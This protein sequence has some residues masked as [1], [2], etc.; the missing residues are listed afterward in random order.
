MKKKLML[1]SACFA[2]SAG[3]ASAQSRVTGTVTDTDGNPVIGATVK[4]EGT[5][6]VTVTDDDGKFSFQSV[7]ASAKHLMV[8]Y[9]GM[10][11]KRV[12]V[13]GNVR[14]TMAYKD[15]ELDEAMVVA[16]GTAKKSSFTGSV[17]EI[18]GDKI[19]TMQLSNIGK[20]LEGALAGVQITQPTGQP[21]EDANIYVR[22]IG[23]I[24]ASKNP[25]IVLDGVPTSL[26]LNAINSK[27]I[28][29]INVLKDAAAAAL[30]GS[31]GSNGVIIITTRKGKAGK[32]NINFEAKWGFNQRGVPAYRTVRN[33]G[34]YYELSWEA[35]R[36]QYM[37]QGQSMLQAGIT[38][39]KNLIT[40]LGGYNAYNVAN[41]R[42]INPVTGL[43]DR[44]ASLL[45]HDD[46][47]DEPFHNGFRQEYNV[48]IDGGNDKTKYYMSFNYLDDG[49][50]VKSSSFERMTGRVNLEHQATRWLQVGVNATFAHTDT[51]T[52]LQNTDPESAESQANGL[53]RFAQF[54]A[55]I[56]PI[57][58]YDASG[59]RL[60][61]DNGSAL[62]DYGVSDGHSRPYAQSANPYGSLNND[63]NS[64]KTDNLA[65]R[66]FAKFDLYDG[67]TFTAN[68]SYEGRWDR[69]IEFQTPVV[70]DA[71]NVNGRGFVRSSNYATVNANQLL[72][73]DKT[74][75]LHGVEALVGHE[76]YSEGSAD[77]YGY[78]EQFFL[79][80][81]PEFDNAAK[82]LSLGS[83]TA[84]YTLESYFGRVQYSYADKYYV[85]GSYR[86]DGS[87]RFHP[88]HRWGNFWSVGA[89]WR[90]KEESW[91][92]DVD[93]LHTLKLKASYGT[94]GNDALPY[95]TPYVDLYVVENVDDQPGLV[96]KFRGNP[97]ITWEKSKNFNVGV[98]V[99]LWN[100]LDVSAEFFVKNTDD[101]L[102]KRLLAF[103]EG[104]PSFYYTNEM[105][106]RNTGVEVEVGAL[107][108]KTR[109][110]TWRA[111]LNLTHYKNELTRLEQGKDPNGY[112]YN[113]YWRKK[114]GSIYDWYL[115]RYVG[116]DPENGDALYLKNVTDEEGN[117]IGTTTTNNSSMADRYEIGKSALPKLYGGLSTTLEGYGF[118]LTIQTAF[119]FGGWVDDS[120]YGSLMSASMGSNYS[121]DIYK[122]WTPNNRYTDVPRL[123]KDN[124]SLNG[125]NSD[126]FLT[127]ASYFSIRNITLGYTLPKG[128]L[129]QYGIQAVRFFAVGDNLFL[130][131][132]RKGFD[133]R[134]NIE[135]TVSQAVYSAV[136]TVSFGLNLQF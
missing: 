80:D 135:G 45:Y 124:T 55:P 88:D 70:G 66:A 29:S 16:Y 108:V 57:Y 105:A 127:K 8:S 113:S 86:R 47:L 106:M 59:N 54:I 116:V 98:E 53:F 63:I 11:A 31:R 83:N 28:E 120:S 71:A 1:V 85:S 48:G 46:W 118:D 25:L 3:I 26:S 117:I 84:K 97:D 51:N 114:G 101:M 93:W 125:G 77:L 10:D 121:P 37:G 64:Y 7:P 24:L 87:S 13:S 79:S 34:D 58:Q 74:F 68:F 133:P 132:A 41:D 19:A 61:D 96:R 75:G 134:Q 82:M 73:Y 5:K 78:K 128:W 107:L 49:S 76:S 109:N 15:T 50:Y 52:P 33:E 12:S 130:G 136:R 43:M 40:E 110:F 122:R 32:T 14:V 9:I 95:S 94:Q 60:Y 30:Y 92:K 6:L 103:T 104:S 62:Y 131:S 39:S 38:A 89:T 2:L 102:T 56:Y 4:V 18:K 69:S 22:G 21:G 20:G 99:G 112:A 119:S 123:E 27:D 35:L 67:L 36:N 100:R 65:A 129:K 42:L 115:Q 17:S 126:R 90:M 23:S 111:N 91:L 81:V 72:N 44:S